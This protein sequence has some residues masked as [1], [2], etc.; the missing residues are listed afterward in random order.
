MVA[1]LLL[2]LT[3]LTSPRGAAVLEVSPNYLQ[4]PPI[5]IHGNLGFTTA[6]GVTGGNGRAADPYIIQGW[7]IDA[8]GTS[9]ISIRNTDSYFVIRNAYVHPGGM[10]STS[11]IPSTAGWRTPPSRATP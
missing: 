10:D 6:N 8:T 1:A 5:A 11:P 7:E 4:H 9:G 2:S 3:A